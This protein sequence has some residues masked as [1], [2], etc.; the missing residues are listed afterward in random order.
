MLYVGV[1]IHSASSLRINTRVHTMLHQWEWICTYNCEW[2]CA[3]NFVHSR[4]VSLKGIATCLATCSDTKNI[5]R[6][7]CMC[8]HSQWMRS[9]FSLQHPTNYMR[10]KILT[11]FSNVRIEF[12]HFCPFCSIWDPDFGNFSN[13]FTSKLSYLWL[14]VKAM[15]LILLNICFVCF[16][17]VTGLTGWR[18]HTTLCSPPVAVILALRVS[19]HSSVPVL[20][21]VSAHRAPLQLHSRDH[22]QSQVRIIDNLSLIIYV[23]GTP[24]ADSVPSTG[25]SISPQSTFTAP[26][27]RPHS[28][29]SKNNR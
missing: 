23:E 22:T 10:L 16:Q 29:T 18:P 9:R 2:I 28:I 5:Y 27:Q 21:T 1:L 14:V 7:V 4:N 6:W 13:F 24:W 8:I 26:Q 25:N 15:H 3:H 12:C 19:P 20:G 17:K 11:F